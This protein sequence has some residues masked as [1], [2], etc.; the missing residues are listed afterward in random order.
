MKELRPLAERK[1]PQSQ[2][3]VGLVH[4]YGLGVSED[5]EKAAFWLRGAVQQGNAPASLRLGILYY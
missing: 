4:Q 3:I 1:D 5:F 2:Y